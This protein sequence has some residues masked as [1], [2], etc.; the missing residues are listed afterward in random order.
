MT[1]TSHPNPPAKVN[2]KAGPRRKVIICSWILTPQWPMY[3]L[4]LPAGL[5][6]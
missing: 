1:I 2:A 6:I 4:G 5:T 3:P